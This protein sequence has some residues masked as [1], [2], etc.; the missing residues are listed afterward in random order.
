MM[1]EQPQFCRLSI[2]AKLRKG[3][4]VAENYEEKDLKLKLKLTLKILK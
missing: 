2:Q 1:L 4:K 3:K